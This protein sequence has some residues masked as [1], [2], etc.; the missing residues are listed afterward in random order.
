M[1]NH[2]KRT[3][4]FV[5]TSSAPFDVDRRPPDYGEEIIG[6]LTKPRDGSTPN[7]Y[8]NFRLALGRI[9]Y[10]GKW[11]EFGATENRGISGLGI[12]TNYLGN[13]METRGI[14]AIQSP[15]NQNLRDWTQD[16]FVGYPSIFPRQFDPTTLTFINTDEPF[17]SPSRGNLPSPTG[18]RALPFLYFLYEKEEK[19]DYII[20][21]AGTSNYRLEREYRGEEFL[22]LPRTPEYWSNSSEWN[23]FITTSIQNTTF[24]DHPF[25]HDMPRGER[26]K[27][28]ASS[29]NVPNSSPFIS[30]EPF[31]N[32]NIPVYENNIQ[33]VSSSLLPNLYMFMAES[34]YYN[35]IDNSEF[36]DHIE[37]G[38]NSQMRGVLLDKTVIQSGFRVVA[39]SGI[40]D[41]TGPSSTGPVGSFTGESDRGQY[42]QNYGSLA[43]DNL[44]AINDW[45]SEAYNGAN[46]FKRLIFPINN[47]RELQNTKTI[48]DRFPMGIK[49]EFSVNTRPANAIATGLLDNNL[50]SYLASNLVN[51]ILQ[52]DFSTSR[53]ALTME[54]ANINPAVKRLAEFE[55]S[56]L[57]ELTPSQ[58]HNTLTIGSDSTEEV[59]MSNIGPLGRRFGISEAVRTQKINQ[60]LNNI[61]PFY[62]AQVR[63][64]SSIMTGE[65]CYTETVFY[66]L[67]KYNENYKVEQEVHFP[68]HPSFNPGDS[69]KY[70]DTQ[71][72][73]NTPYHYS[74]WEWKVVIGNKLDYRYKDVV[75]IDTNQTVGNQ[76]L[77]FPNAAE[78]CVFNSPYVKVFMVP[79]YDSRTDFPDGIRVLDKPPITPDVNVIPYKGI[80][81]KI[82][83]WL[84]GGTG[85]YLLPDIRIREGELTE[86]ED[87]KNR[88]GLINF[89][90][91]DSAR[92]FEIWRLDKKPTSY[93]D[94]SEMRNPFTASTNGADASSYI[95][96]ILPNKKY[97]Y[98]FRTVDIHGHT[99][100][101]GDVY[102]VELVQ[103]DQNVFSIINVIDMEEINNKVTKK[104]CKK[105]L[106]IEPSFLQMALDEVA[107]EDLSDNYNSNNPPNK[108][109]F[110]KLSAEQSIFESNPSKQKS[111]KIRLTSKKTGKK[112][113]LNLKFKIRNDIE[114][115]K[116][117]E[118]I[119]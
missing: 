12:V 53:F 28:Q 25:S 54:D 89:A 60:F 49:L 106:K 48:E 58:Q 24:Y 82:Q 103:D 32:Y 15:A 50:F 92:Y 80:E 51:K 47:I 18:I 11:N 84:N 40:T 93:V 111:Y 71:V 99:S 66:T 63:N 119:N 102:E 57:L 64:I 56:K 108:S 30:I 110:I 87:I 36:K 91:D 101:P 104:P 59:R 43:R 112:I 69:I 90:S 29:Q 31:Y 46:P 115:P 8:D 117:F 61:R 77:N 100:N 109:E 67:Y 107:L 98:T 19:T 42:F 23:S 1:S 62:T 70:I 94:F 3:I 34:Y 72:K 22:N 114:A 74:L 4:F 113:D 37:V 7:Q 95:D 6:T 16:S 14:R 2:H 44:S 55:L 45:A 86:R 68:H 33:N 35:D 21:A 38:G 5:Q 73:Y 78:I 10:D 13:D 52:G 96:T 9:W 79:I 83:I 85:D 88:D 75:D 118:I 20:V 27:L 39:S 116:A 81:D 97:Y 41:T 26:K 17:P 105:F 65:K 76:V